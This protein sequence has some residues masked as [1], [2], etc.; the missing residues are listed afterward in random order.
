MSAERSDDGSWLGDVM[1]VYGGEDG[2]SS[3]IGMMR[4]KMG[5]FLNSRRGTCR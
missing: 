3:V 5:N 1:M 4:S 2:T